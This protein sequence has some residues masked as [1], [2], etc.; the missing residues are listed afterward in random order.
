MR[1]P[2]F[3][4]GIKDLRNP[5]L[6]SAKQLIVFSI[7]YCSMHNYSI[8]A[9]FSRVYPEQNCRIGENV[10]ADASNLREQILLRLIRLLPVIFVISIEVLYSE[11]WIQWGLIGM[12]IWGLPFEGQRGRWHKFVK[13]FHPFLTVLLSAPRLQT[14]ESFGFDC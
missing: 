12:F 6:F 3:K 7:L 1:C 5:S 13:S 11:D 8:T 14:P 9:S 2:Y 10:S 4:G